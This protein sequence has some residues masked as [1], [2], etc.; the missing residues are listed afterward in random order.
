[1][2]SS[3]VIVRQPVHETEPRHTPGKRSR[4]ARLTEPRHTP[5]KRSRGIRPANGAATPA[6]GTLPCSRPGA[7]RLPPS[8]CVLNTLNQNKRD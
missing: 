5:G 1:M 2:T 4:N 3:F 6:I 8:E 7:H